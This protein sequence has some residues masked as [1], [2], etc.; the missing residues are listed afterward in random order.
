MTFGEI[1]TKY[2]ILPLLQQ[3]LVRVAYVGQT[4]ALNSTAKV[5]TDHIIRACLLHDMGNIIKFNFVAIPEAVEDKGL[6]YW[7][8]IKAAFIEKYGNDEV[9]ASH[10]ICQE[11]NLDREILEL[12]ESFGTRNVQNIIDSKDLNKMI[13][14]YSDHRVAPTG[15]VSLKE[16]IQDQHKRFMKSFPSEVAQQKIQSRKP[17][18]DAKFELERLIFEKSKINADAIIN[19]DVNLLLPKFLDLEL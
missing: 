12:V 5:K 15:I 13:V 2:N 4:I 8:S 19:T 14:N 7:E 1:Y 3:H 18:D 16:R 11:L 17:T 10:I 6:E 9:A